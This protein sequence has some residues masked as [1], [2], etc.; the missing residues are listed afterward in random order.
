[1]TAT[2]PAHTVS[3][4]IDD[5]SSAVPK[6]CVKRRLAPDSSNFPSVNG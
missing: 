4:G 6:D 1:M 3:V 5:E 2:L